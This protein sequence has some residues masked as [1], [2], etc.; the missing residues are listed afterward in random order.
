MNFKECVSNIKKPS[1]IRTHIPYGSEYKFVRDLNKRF[2][3]NTVCQEAACPNIRDCWSRKHATYMILGKICTRGCKFCNVVTEKPLHIDTD[4]PKNIARAVKNLGLKYVVITSVTR[5]DLYN[6]GLFQYLHTVMEI[7]HLNSDTKIE[8]LI[9]DFGANPIRK[10]SDNKAFSNGA[11]KNYIYKIANCGVEVIGHNIEMV[12]RLYPEIRPDSDYKNS[13]NVLRWLKEFNSN[14][15]TKSSIMVGF[16]E[17]KRGLNR[18]IKEVADMK[19]DILHIGQYL[20]PSFKHVKVK[21]YYTDRE[22]EELEKITKDYGIRVVK[23]GPMVRSSYKAEESYEKVLKTYL[24]RLNSQNESLEDSHHKSL[25]D[26]NS[27]I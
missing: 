22:F 2:N 15:I 4:E 20:Q 26:K 18:T 5:D 8:L 25:A 3:L 27:T 14:L 23:T 1:W 24:S 13:L 17:T 11:S 12:S 10:Y 19:I 9:P 6:K 21:K 16:G 7:K